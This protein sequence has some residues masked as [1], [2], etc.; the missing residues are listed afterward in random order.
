MKREGRV[1]DTWTAD[2]RIYVKDNLDH[3]HVILQPRDLEKFSAATEPE[4]VNAAA[5]PTKDIPIV[6]RRSTSWSA[7]PGP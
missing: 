3:K 6:T 5:D 1:K 7:I 4:R 2:G